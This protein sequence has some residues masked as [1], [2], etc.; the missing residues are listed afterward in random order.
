[1]AR[2]WEDSWQQEPNLFKELPTGLKNDTDNKVLYLV[3]DFWDQERNNDKWR[4][5]KDLGYQEENPLKAQANS[6]AMELEQ[7]RILVSKLLDQLR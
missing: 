5:W 3:K 1:M 6:L 7:R 4:T 2:F